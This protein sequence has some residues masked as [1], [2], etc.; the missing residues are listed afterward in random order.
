MTKDNCSD[1]GCPKGWKPKAD[2]CYL[3]YEQYCR[4]SSSDL[5][6]IRLGCNWLQ[7]SLGCEKAGGHLAELIDETKQKNILSIVNKEV[8]FL[9]GSKII[10]YKKSP[11]KN[12]PKIPL[13]T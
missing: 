4:K 5:S 6:K 8:C 1:D 11:K 12:N 13:F 3:P 10:Y 2:S 7:A 9:P